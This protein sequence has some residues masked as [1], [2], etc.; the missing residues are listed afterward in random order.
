MDRRMRTFR[1]KMMDRPAELLG[2]FRLR[3]QVYEA[4][5]YL[6]QRSYPSRLEIDEYDLWSKPIGAFDVETGDCVG[7]LRLIHSRLPG[8]RAPL[9]RS[10]VDAAD[11]P[12]LRANVMRPRLRPL[13]SITSDHVQERLVAHN[14]DRLEVMELGRAIVHLT[15]RGAGVLRGLIELGLAGAMAAGD[16]MVIADCLPEHVAMHARHGFQIL[17]GTGIDR[18]ERVGRL[19]STIV[20]DTRR[21]PEPT[22]SHVASLL[23]AMRAGETELLFEQHVPEEGGKPRGAWRFAN[24]ARAPVT[25]ERERGISH[26]R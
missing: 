7:T 12:A 4:T 26:P 3:Y 24:E 9:I 22:R 8:A 2:S 11:D 19:A 6:G 14:V 25:S 13:P 21:L 23:D 20:C 1:I 16:A 15:C 17:P 10:L 5:G 18:H